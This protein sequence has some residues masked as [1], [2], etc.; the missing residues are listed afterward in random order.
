MDHCRGLNARRTF[1]V[2]ALAGAWGLP[3]LLPQAVSHDALERPDHVRSGLG[4]HVPVDDQPHEP[5]LLL[6]RHDDAPAGKSVHELDVD[7]WVLGRWSRTAWPRRKIRW[8]ARVSPLV[9]HGAAHTDRITVGFAG[10]RLDTPQI[11]EVEVSNVG[12]KDFE[13]AHFL[14]TPIEIMLTGGTVVSTLRETSEPT[15][16]RVLHATEH[17]DRVALDTSTPLHKGQTVQQR[18]SLKVT[19]S[20]VD[21]EAAGGPMW[22]V[23]ELEGF[24]Q[25]GA[26]LM[27]ISFT[28]TSSDSFDAPD[29]ITVDNISLP[30]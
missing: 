11:I 10:T 5:V 19:V 22:G 8:S 6:D 13:P 20:Q 2:T 4:A 21:N 17:G 24:I 28:H 7:L 1:P 16:R 27:S 12:N 14:G 25:P 23:I 30:S 15:V 26:R 18:G 3:V 29:N 9:S